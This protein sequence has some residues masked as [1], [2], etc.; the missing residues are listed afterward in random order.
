M[1]RTMRDKKEICFLY[2][3]GINDCFALILQLLSQYFLHLRQGNSKVV[4]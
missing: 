2:V 1:E 4:N 3:N